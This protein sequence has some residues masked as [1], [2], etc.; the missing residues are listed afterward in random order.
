MKRGPSTAPTPPW[1]LVKAERDRH[2]LNYV[3]PPGTVREDSSGEIWVVIGR[4]SA[5][6]PVG[7]HVY[8]SEADG[9][10]QVVGQMTKE[11]IDFGGR[12]DEYRRQMIASELSTGENY[13]IGKVAIDGKTFFEIVRISR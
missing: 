13:R 8:F 12:F 5:P 3:G 11:G 2:P 7:E 9:R 6:V 4:N 1:E 10:L